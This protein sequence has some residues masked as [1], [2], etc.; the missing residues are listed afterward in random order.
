MGLRKAIRIGLKVF[1]RKTHVI[2]GN[3]Q[4][5]ESKVLE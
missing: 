3:R 5:D 2:V 1:Q 4:Q